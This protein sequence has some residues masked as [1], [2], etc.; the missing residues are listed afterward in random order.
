VADLRVDDDTIFHRREK[1]TRSP[2]AAQGRAQSGPW[3]AAS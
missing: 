1:R 3:Q 2:Q